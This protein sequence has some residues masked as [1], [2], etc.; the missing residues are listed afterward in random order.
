MHISVF[1]Y[2]PKRMGDFNE[3]QYKSRQLKRKYKQRELSRLKNEGLQTRQFLE[4]S[5]GKRSV[6]TL[7]DD[8]SLY[9]CKYIV[10]ADSISEK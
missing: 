3:Y 7:C 5:I 9:L 8:I 2:G 4:Q 10:Y 1:S 6:S